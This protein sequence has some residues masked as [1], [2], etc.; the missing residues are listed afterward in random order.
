MF[1][2]IMSTE[3]ITNLKKE[4]YTPLKTTESKDKIFSSRVDINHL[5]ARARKQ[6]QKD[7]FTNLVFF[8]LFVALVVIS[9]IILSL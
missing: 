9:G 6:Q 4:N 1:Y 7:S 3:I 5:L 2:S 8:G